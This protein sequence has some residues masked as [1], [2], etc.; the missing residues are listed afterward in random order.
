MDSSSE[1]VKRRRAAIGT[2]IFASVAPSTVLGVIPYL[3][4][5][6]RVRH[7]V[8]GGTPARVT[9]GALLAAGVSV[10]ASSFV[11][12]ARE[13]LGTPAPVAPPE[14]LVVGG[15]YRHVR[16]P[17]YVAIESVLL[18]QALLLG[19]PRLFGMAAAATLPV[20]TF[21]K[22]YEEPTL[23]KQFGA[24]YAEYRRNVPAW[25]P[26]LIPWKAPPGQTS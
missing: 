4:T 18:G 7:P 2:A 17:M 14:H 24:E 26:R 11:R 12:F 8:P 22:L 1:H 10:I 9:G 23:S 13:G 5:G 15:M 16:N 3:L 21:V 6:W 19:Q 25:F 20:A